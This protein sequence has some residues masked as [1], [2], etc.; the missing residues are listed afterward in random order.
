VTGEREVQRVRTPRRAAVGAV[1]AAAAMAVALGAA[2]LAA[3]TPT[4]EPKPTGPPH[5]HTSAAMFAQCPAIGFDTG[6][7]ILIVV[8]P[9]G[10]VSVLTDPSQPPFENVEDTLVG[11]Q[12]NAQAVVTSLTLTGVTTP[13]PTFG[14]DDDG[15]C[16]AVGGGAPPPA[17]CP[18]GSTGYEGPG[19]SF[20]NISA[21]M[22]DG[23]V[24]FF[25]GIGPGGTAFFS[26]EGAISATNLTIAPITVPKPAPA[27]MVVV[28]APRFT[29]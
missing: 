13:D 11:V 8:N 22:A 12:N 28:V 20:S 25:P 26:L 19:T 24:N 29:G 9:D 7:G 18:F 10:T 1:L 16:H 23:T 3:Q 4:P 14:F 17:A 6:C 5:V 15:L 2:P 27:P 21:D